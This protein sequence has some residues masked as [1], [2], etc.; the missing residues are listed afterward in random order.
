M[1]DI[2]LEY[3]LGL[4]GIVASEIYSSSKKNNLETTN[5]VLKGGKKKMKSSSKK[6]KKEGTTDNSKKEGTNDTSKIENITDK[7]SKNKFTDGVNKGAKDFS[8]GME[9][10]G[11]FL[12]SIVK[13]WQLVKLGLI[14]AIV[15]F[16]IFMGAPAFFII[17]ILVISWQFLKNQINRYFPSNNSNPKLKSNSNN[18]NNNNNN[19]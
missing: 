2:N 11:N 3:Y 14:I 6:S 19:F 17:S 8:N 1:T 18:N 9:S 13:P 5:N 10:A 16:L 12:L 7:A 15:L 4:A